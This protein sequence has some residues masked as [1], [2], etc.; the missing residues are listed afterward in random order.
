MITRESLLKSKE[1][2]LGNI[3]DDLYAIVEDYLQK[4]NLTPKE[5]AEKLGVSERYIKKVL[6]GYFDG[7]LTKLVELALS[8]G[9]APIV[10]F[11][12]VEIVKMK[13]ERILA[14]AIWFDDGK[15]HLYQPV[16]ISTGLVFCGFRHCSIF[17]QIGGT[18]GERKNVG[19]KE[20]E[21]GF[22]TY[23]NRFVGREEAASI[24]FQSGQIQVEQKTLYSEDLW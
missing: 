21:Q 13:P 5:F 14:A 6:A 15:E 22:L 8:V 12:D 18:V 4:N 24:A 19:I 10:L 20:K 23:H 7:K 3:Q 17:Q 2:Q 16:N 11:Q 9:K 1:Y